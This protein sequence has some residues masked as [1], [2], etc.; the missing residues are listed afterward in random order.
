M[1]AIQVRRIHPN[2][3]IPKFQTKGSAGADV[4]AAEDVSIPPRD[5]RLVPLGLVVAI[6]E[7]YELQVRPRSGL[8]ANHSIT[9]LNTPGT[10]DSDFRG[11]LQVLLINHGPKTFMISKGDRIAQMVCQKVPSVSYQE[12]D[13]IDITLRGTG[14]FG[15]TGKK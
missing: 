4:Y 5:V 9:V 1:V 6:P 12:V 10:I 13:E 2:A 3:I 7:G 14:G 11:N 15:S 8:A